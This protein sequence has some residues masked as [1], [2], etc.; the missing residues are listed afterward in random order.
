MYLIKNSYYFEHVETIQ[1][2]FILSLLILDELGLIRPLF[3]SLSLEG[4][5]LLWLFNPYDVKWL[6]VISLVLLSIGT[7]GANILQDVLKDLV[8]DI[9]KSQDQNKARSLARAAIWSRIAYLSGVMSAILWVATDAVGGVHPYWRSTFLICLITMTTT[10]IIFCASHNIYHQGELTKR[11]AE[12]FFRMFGARIKKLLKCNLRCFL[13]DSRQDRSPKNLEMEKIESEGISQERPIHHLDTEGEEVRGTTFNQEDMVVVKS[14]LRMF[15]MWGM[16]LVVSIISATGFTFFLQQYS[17]LYLSDK[18][19]I[20]IYNI[21][22]D[23]SRFSIL[24]LYRWICSL[25]KKEKVKIGIGM[26][27]GIISCIFAWQLEV[28]RLKKVN[29]EDDISSISFLWLVPQFYVLGCMEGLTMDG[30]LKFYRS[31]MKEEPLLISYGEEYIEIVMGLGK[32]INILLILVFDSQSGWF[33]DT[34]NESRLDKYYLV[35]VYVCSANFILYCFIATY[36]YKDLE[37]AD[38]N[39]KQDDQPLA[40][41][42]QKYGTLVLAN[43]DQKQDK[44]VLA[45]EYGSISRVDRRRSF[46]V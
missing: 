18:I 26:L 3:K 13:K 19:P 11:P 8:N 35:L 30:L 41:N 16:F 14:L 5:M 40:G 45:S 46:K 6:V 33:G 25:R 39:Q 44:H 42:D 1:Y 32:L 29:K 20:Q 2:E 36:F 21:V 10:S 12:V 27:C 15:P 43:D 17:N 38:D 31:Q 24:F 28:H 23:F 7:S 9:D 34:I 22:Q 4:L 37:L